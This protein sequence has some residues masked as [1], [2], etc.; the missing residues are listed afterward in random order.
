M[1]IVGLTGS[2]GMGKSTVAGRLKELGVPVCDADAIVHELYEGEAVGPV[3]AAFPG[4]VSD[5][6][7]D[8]RLLSRKLVADPDGFKKLESIVHPLVQ[9]KEREFLGRQFASGVALAVIEVPLLFETYGD[10]RMDVTLVVSAPYTIQKERVLQRPGMSEAKFNEI[11]S[12]QLSDKEKRRR[13]DFVVDTGQDMA[14]SF[15]EVDVIIEAL[16]IRK[17]TAFARYWKSS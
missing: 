13:A 3:E 17:G 4:T 15:A 10:A 6:K 1:L 16:K 14:R 9:A 7:I 5:G 2:I 11:L 8:R 12:R